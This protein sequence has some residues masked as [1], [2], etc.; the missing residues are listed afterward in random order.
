MRQHKGIIQN[1]VVLK[2][3]WKITWGDSLQ[4]PIQGQFHIKQDRI[5]KPNADADALVGKGII[6]T[7]DDT[8]LVGRAD[9]FDTPETP[10]LP[11]I[12]PIFY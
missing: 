4:D 5:R 1:I 2:D 7:S 12:F 10:E 9:I 3:R 8:N 6:I 11:Y